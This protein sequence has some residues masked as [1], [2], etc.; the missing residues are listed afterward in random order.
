[1]FDDKGTCVRKSY[2]DH[3]ADDEHPDYFTYTINGKT[4]TLKE[5]KGAFQNVFEIKS[6]TSQS[7]VLYEKG[8]KED[9]E[10]FE[11]TY[12]YKRM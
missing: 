9:G 10:R 2:T 4:L 12:I 11:Y 1:M 8:E 5:S 6:L 7:L 3:A